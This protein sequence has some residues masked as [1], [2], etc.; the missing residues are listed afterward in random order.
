M[1]FLRNQ[2]ERRSW[3]DYWRTESRAETHLLD[4][5]RNLPAELQTSCEKK[6]VPLGDDL[7]T[8]H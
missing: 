3:W 7:V 2:E 1:I 6:T 5:I 4:A 8:F